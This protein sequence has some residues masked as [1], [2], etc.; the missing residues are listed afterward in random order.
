MYDKF[1]IIK[2]PP[3]TP[4][5]DGLKPG[6]SVVIL[7]SDFFNSLSFE[8]LRNIY[9]SIDLEKWKRLVLRHM[10]KNAKTFEDWLFILGHS[11]DRNIHRMAE[12]KAVK[13][14]NSTSALLLLLNNYNTTR[15]KQ[16]EAINKALRIA[17]D[18]EELH[19]LRSICARAGMMIEYHREET[20][21][22][23]IYALS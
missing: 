3:P 9:F 23:L 19:R 5:F 17:A 8:S 15:K 13:F 10:T 7:S 1:K 20:R 16:V 22:A 4:L 2:N 18:N 11:T 14:A 21:R 6:G 12:K